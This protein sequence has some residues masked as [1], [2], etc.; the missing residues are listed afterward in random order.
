MK[1]R[2]EYQEIV[3]QP[4]KFELQDV[5]AP[6]FYDLML[7]GNGEYDYNSVLRF[8]ITDQDLKLFPEL[9]DYKYVELHES[10]FDFIFVETFEKE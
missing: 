2:K 9:S 3:K 7:D 4:G 6:Y 8:E 10:E 5:Y 1:T